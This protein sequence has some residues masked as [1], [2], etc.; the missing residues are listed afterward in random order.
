[1]TDSH[2]DGHD[3]STGPDLRRLPGAKRLDGSSSS[4]PPQTAS[5]APHD[6][7]LIAERIERDGITLTAELGGVRLRAFKGPTEVSF[8]IDDAG[9]DHLLGLL[10]GLEGDR[11]MR[12]EAEAETLAFIDRM[13]RMRTRRI[14]GVTWYTES[15]VEE[16]DAF[17]VR[18]GIACTKIYR[19]IGRRR[20]EIR[21]EAVQGAS[22]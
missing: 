2:V 17:A 14:G 3:Y 4:K 10:I 18:K 21:N 16:I 9:L 6:H 22:V 19:L 11:R 15:E 1:M 7:G 5:F 20:A 8:L 13:A 12:A